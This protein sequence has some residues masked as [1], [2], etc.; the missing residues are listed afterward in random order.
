M[1][2]LKIT[3]ANGDITEHQI[4]P[5]IEYACELYAK[6]G[7]HKAFR[8]DEKQSDIYWLAWECIRTSGETVEPFGAAFLD[9]LVRVEV[10]DD[11]PLEQWGAVTLVTSQR[12]QPLKRVSR[13]SICQTLMT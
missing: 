6:K 2:R 11:A 4:T 8:D 13:P 5:R 12:S 1:A 10:L 3:R 7:F 9:T